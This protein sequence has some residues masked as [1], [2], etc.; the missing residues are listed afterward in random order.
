MTLAQVARPD[1]EI[2]HEPGR[3]GR[4]GAG[5]AG[6]PVTA[7]QRRQGFDLPPVR[8]EVSEHQ[9]IER[10]CGCG[11]RTRGTAP[12][13]AE[14]PV[15]YGPR[16]ASLAIGRR[17]WPRA[18]FVE[19]GDLVVGVVSAVRVQVFDQAADHRPGVRQRLADAAGERRVVY[20]AAPGLLQQVRGNRQ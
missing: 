18:A 3:C 8:A 15:Q 4:C 12:R 11:H 2:Q 7:V 1:R 17:S 5:L 14:A 16:T 20:L 10:E 9:L 13:G 6:R 19:R